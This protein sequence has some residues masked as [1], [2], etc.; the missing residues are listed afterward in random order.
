[1]NIFPETVLH[2]G[3]C[4]NSTHHIQQFCNFPVS[5]M[6]FN[7]YNTSFSSHLMIMPVHCFLV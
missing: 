2:C 3:W 6:F 5:S 7:H 4:K 1:M